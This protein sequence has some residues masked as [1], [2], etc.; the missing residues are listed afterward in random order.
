MSKPKVSVIVTTYNNATDLPKC[1]ESLLSQ[2]LH[3]IEIIVLNDCST[4]STPEVVAQFAERDTRIVALHNEENL[5]LSA[6]RNR[7]MQTAHADYVMFCDGDDYYSPNM[8]EKMFRAIKDSQADF[9][10]C[11]IKVIYHAHQEMKVSDDHYY[12]LKFRGLQTIT[13]EIVL[14]TNYSADNK[15]FRKALIDQYQL[16]F[17]V[18]RRYED[19]Y[20]CMAYFCIAKTAFYLPEQLYYYIRHAGSIMSQTWSKSAKTDI[21]ID[22]LYIMFELYDFLQK[23][24]LFESHAALFW[25]LFA[26]YENLALTHSKSTKNRQKVKKEAKGFLAAHTAELKTATPDAQKQ[27]RRMNSPL[28][29]PNL[30]RLKLLARKL[31]PTYR[32]AAEN[33]IALA[34]LQSETTNLLETVQKLTQE[35]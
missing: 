23:H 30:H 17:P 19:A 29:R 13:N 18:G 16:E 28:P 34:K 24:K 22:H 12:H 10:I 4:D 26:L 15:I 14:H 5:G 33:A 9:A 32:L 35:K 6:T 25:Q 21:A 3:D 27:L 20:F 7:G 31:F 8:C 11:G 2:T 1:L